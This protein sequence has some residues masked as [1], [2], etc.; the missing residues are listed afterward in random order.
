[1]VIAGKAADEILN[2]V[3][4]GNE[5]NGET[6]CVVSSEARRFFLNK[7]HYT[8]VFIKVPKVP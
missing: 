1:M 8:M 7:L 6:D 3:G 4:V 5:N 2:A